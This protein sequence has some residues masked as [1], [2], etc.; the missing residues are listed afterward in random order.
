MHC[1]S[2]VH[3]VAHAVPPALHTVTGEHALGP[4]V[5]QVPLPLHVLA[6]NEPLAQVSVQVPVGPLG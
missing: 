5:L 2:L 4:V 1:V 3:V 6:V